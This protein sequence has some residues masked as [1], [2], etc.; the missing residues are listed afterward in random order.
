M[1]CRHC[2]QTPAWDQLCK[3]NWKDI[4]DSCMAPIEYGDFPA[5][6]QANCTVKPSILCLGNR[7]FYKM[8]KCNWTSGYSWTTTLILS[9]TLGG[10]GADR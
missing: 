4:K 6:I 10:F 8:I 2:Y 5:K 1:V 3:G 7:V 9:I